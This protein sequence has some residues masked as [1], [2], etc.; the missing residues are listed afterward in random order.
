MFLC[1]VGFVFVLWLILFLTILS[2]GRVEYNAS[3]TIKPKITDSPYIQHE[4]V[5][6]P[7][8]VGLGKDCEVIPD[9]VIP[10]FYMERPVVNTVPE[11]SSLLLMVLPLI[12]IWRLR[13]K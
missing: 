13:S 3:Y 6:I 2:E 5:S 12:Y 1:S 11:P 4:W 8:C 9:Y 7:P 10:D